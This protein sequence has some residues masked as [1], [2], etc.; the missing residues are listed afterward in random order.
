[1]ETSDVIRFLEGESGTTLPQNIRRSLQEWGAQ[2]ERIVFR[3]GISLLQAADSELLQKLQGD[4]HVNRHLDRTVSPDV[5]SLKPG[6]ERNLVSRLV[7]LGILP[8]VSGGR[9]EGAEE[10]IVI[11]EDGTLR[12]AQTVPSLYL[13]GQL[14][15]MAEQTGDGTWK[16]TRGS[17]AR[18]AGSREKVVLLLSELQA[19]SGDPLAPGLVD[20]I[21]AWG[22]YFG[23]AAA[24]CVTL[25]EFSDRDVMKELCKRPELRP[26]LRAFRAG[27]RALAV[28]ASEK[29]ADVQGILARLGVEV[30]DGLSS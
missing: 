4:S 28:V 30:R 11:E 6:R 20:Q 23:Q 15:R 12:P 13:R 16:L 26:L 19:L 29:L 10:G 1:M 7:S 14:S 3:S 2:H 21:K 5:A 17:V 27:D 9:P 18:A 22:G 25:I 8:A 24:E